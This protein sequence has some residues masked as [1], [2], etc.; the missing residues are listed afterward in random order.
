MKLAELRVR[1]EITGI[2]LARV[3]NNEW[4]GHIGEI[5]VE[6]KMIGEN[7]IINCY[8]RSTQ[9]IR[10]VV[11][12]NRTIQSCISWTRLDTIKVVSGANKKEIRNVIVTILGC[13]FIPY[14]FLFQ[15]SISSSNS[16]GST[17]RLEFHILTIAPPGISP[18]LLSKQTFSSVF[19]QTP[20]T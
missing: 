12:E 10:L 19:I 1:E 20:T 15:T 11:L 6:S 16:D 5:W 14:L 17:S 4:K 2:L 3:W 8:Y 13:N 18:F 7:T 9:F